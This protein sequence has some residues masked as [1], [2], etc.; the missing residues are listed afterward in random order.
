MKRPV[1]KNR[2]RV[3]N[4]LGPNAEG[5]YVLYWMT[6]FRR[7]EHNFALQRAVE[8]ALELKRPLLVFE[9]LKGNYPWACPRFHQFVIDGVLE[10]AGGWEHPGAAYY[11]FVENQVGA[12]RGLLAALAEG[13]GVVVSDDF[14]CFFIPEMLRAASSKLPVRLE[15]VDSN[16]L[17]PLSVAGKEFQRAYDYRRYL[18]KNLRGWLDDPLERPL[19][20]LPSRPLKVPERIRKQWPGASLEELRHPDALFRRLGFS[21]GPGVVDTSGGS[22]AARQQLGEFLESRL[23]H[24]SRQRNE[25]SAE[26]TSRLSPFLHFGFIS[27]HEVL[28]ETLKKTGCRPHSLEAARGKV[29]D[30]WPDDPS[31]CEFLD[32][33]VTWRELGFNCCWHRED[34][35]RYE[36]LPAWARK[37]LS[38]HAADPR[39]ACYGLEE[40]ARAE[41]HDPVWNAA[42]RQLLQEGVIHNYLRML[43]GKKIL[44]WSESPEKALQVMIELNN[45]YAL[46]GRDP[47][48]Y[49]GIFWCLGRYDRP[50]GPERLV[51]G[52]IR[53]MSS[54]NTARKFNLKPYLERYGEAGQGQKSLF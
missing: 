15:A 22:R 11:P 19:E 44:H 52:K 13:A 2:I 25:P 29:E 12:Q 5:D 43:W 38:E 33:L 32:Q 51:F 27:A 7:L 42:Q 23:K 40:F 53:Y 1:P 48:S 16:G 49:S 41:T 36:S 4:G 31:A 34:Y 9:A 21:A 45:R 14:P 18:Q 54:R 37:T 6:S 17:L 35:D 47:N 10:K 24:Y 46:D 30:W 20:A 39:E 50:W 28:R 8:W 3:L 26:A